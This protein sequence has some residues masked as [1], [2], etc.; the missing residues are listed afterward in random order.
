MYWRFF[1]NGTQFED[2]VNWNGAKFNIKLDRER[3]MYKFGYTTDVEFPGTAAGYIKTQTSGICDPLDVLVEKR[4]SK[5]EPWTTFMQ[6]L[7]FPTDM[8]W[9]VNFCKVRVRILDNSLSSRLFNNW[10]VKAHLHIDKSKNGETIPTPAN[11][12]IDFF[13]PQNG[14][15]GTKDNV[16]T[17]KVYDALKF[18]VSYCSDGKMDFHSDY[19]GPGGAKE[20]L[21]ISTGAALRNPG[22]EGYA[23]Y[24]SFGRLYTDLRKK[25]NLIGYQDHSG[26]VPVLR[27]EPLPDTR[28]SLSNIL[29]EAVPGMKQDYASEL[30]YAKVLTGSGTTQDDDGGGFTFPDI[31]YFSHKAEEFHML[32]ECN[33]DQTLDL[34]GTLV[35]DSNVI[36]DVLVNGN[37]SHDTDVFL[38]ETDLPTADHATRY[39]TFAQ[40]ATFPGVYNVGLTTSALMANNWEGYIPSS[41]AQF[42]GD[43]QDGFSAQLAAD[44]PTA[45]GVLVRNPVATPLELA[46]E[47]S[48]PNGNYDNAAFM[49]EAPVS[50]YYRFG[51]DIRLNSIVINPPSTDSWNVQFT[52]ERFTSTGVFVEAKTFNEN[53]ITD[54]TFSF[55]WQPGGFYG[56]ANDRFY[57]GCL[58]ETVGAGAPTTLNL[59]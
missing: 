12:R 49:Y 59:D 17:Y 11:Q 6:G 33:L 5:R 14:L 27:I 4:A 9:D 26:P 41:L 28:Q 29:Y 53:G 8:L 37:D 50:G 2:P 25:Y 38:V 47:T 1:L 48:D 55:D 35:I 31:T 3:M 21:C 39:L 18:L 10:N 13:I 58:I 19:F 44:I 23:P 15:Y 57:V 36:E 54:P 51:V 52:V 32:G 45:S 22:L 46:N 20:G 7:V 24:L 42:V 30:A 40:G 56:D 34:R 16:Q 43:G